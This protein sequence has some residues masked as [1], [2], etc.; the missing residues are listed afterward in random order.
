MLLLTAQVSCYVVIIIIIIIV[1]ASL[2]L[3]MCP[4]YDRQPQY[5]CGHVVMLD[6][7]IFFQP[8]QEFTNNT[9]VLYYRYTTVSSASVSTSKALKV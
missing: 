2:L 5:S 7:Q 8:Q 4:S 3:A 6:T 9:V 1:K